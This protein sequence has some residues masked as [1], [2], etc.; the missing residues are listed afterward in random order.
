[1]RQQIIHSLLASLL[2]IQSVLPCASAQ[3]PG[4]TEGQTANGSKNDTADDSP[5]AESILV[6]RSQ[7]TQHQDFPR[8]PVPMAPPHIR[9]PRPRPYSRMWQ[10]PQ[11]GRHAAIGA[12][13]GLGLGVA[14]GIKGNQDQH[15]QARIGAPILFGAVGALMGAAIGGSH[16]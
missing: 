5:A 2:L 1:M 12:L 8:R 7:Y 15:P 13:I 14:I 4:Q 6:A 10:Q 16:P 3:T 9:Y 11:N